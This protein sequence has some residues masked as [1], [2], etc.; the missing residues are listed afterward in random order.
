MRKHAVWLLLAVAVVVPARV[1]LAPTLASAHVAT[2]RVG[3]SMILTPDSYLG[4][5][6]GFLLHVPTGLLAPAPLVL[7]LHGLRQDPTRIRAFSEADRIADR[8]GFVVAYP[9]GVGGSWN[10][11]TC[12]GDAADH[13]VDDVAFLDHVVAIARRNALIDPARIYLEG[14]SNGGMMA[15]RFACERPGLV[16]AVAVVAASVTSPCAPDAPVA[17]LDLHGGLDAT[18]PVRGGPSHQLHMAFVPIAT[19]LGVFAAQG[20]DVRVEVL[21]RATHRWMTQAT[22]GLD[23]SSTL[24]D[25]LRDHP[26]PL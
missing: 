16:A 15:L 22:D 11:G 8:N 24:W 14:Y 12:C 5:Q 19:A 18:V 9:G 3:T 17:A 21:P 6:R 7:V 13:Q 4:R 26:K 2:A 10:A 25:W 1:G 23:A 20:A